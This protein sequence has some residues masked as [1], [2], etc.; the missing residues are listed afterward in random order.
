M[1][2]PVNSSALRA[3]TSAWL[4]W[5]RESCRHNK[6]ATDNRR[7]TFELVQEWMWKVG[8]SFVTFWQF[9]TGAEGTDETGL[10]TRWTTR[11]KIPLSQTMAMHDKLP[12]EQKWWSGFSLRQYPTAVLVCRI[13]FSLL[14]T[15][16]QFRFIFKSCLGCVW[17][18][19]K[20]VI[21][22]CAYISC[23][24][25]WICI[26]R[27]TAHSRISTFLASCDWECTLRKDA[28]SLPADSVS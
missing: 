20:F 7:L 23:N 27:W 22:L 1:L 16:A 11:K 17:T 21:F 15:S 19:R 18:L 26:W 6:T 12:A 3:S 5:F 10:Q 14:S 24:D 13:V 25:N 9:G 8:L 4:C 28:T 2:E